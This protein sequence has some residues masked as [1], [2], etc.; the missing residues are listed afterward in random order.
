MF[1]WLG[2]LFSSKTAIDQGRDNPALQAAVLRA[3]EIYDGLPGKAFIDET[4]R[5]RQARQLYLD[6][7]EIFGAASPTA[8]VRQKIASEML[9]FAL[10][11]V[12][13]IPPPPQAD[14]SGLRGLP[15]I[16][17]ELGKQ[18]RKIV[19]HNSEL[20]AELFEG[21]ESVD[22]DNDDETIVRLLKRSFWQA[23]WSL[24]S[25]NAVRKDIGDVPETNDWYKP[26][27]FAACANQENT[28][29]TDV[30]MPS[31]F[32]FPAA[33]AAPVAY[34]LFTDIVLS[35]SPDPLAEWS[36]YHRGAGIPLPEMPA[37]DP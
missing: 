3:A 4:S 36:E 19:K 23:R 26:F 28:Y 16:S 1:K 14:D 22:D 32:E 8:I 18:L 9:R 15:G 29:R 30:G 7:H 10:F 27:M 20:H 35:G 17:G 34:S 24:D 33:A 2:N 5:R 6:L 31:A 21:I 11:Q 37:S 25:Y 13:L 12:L